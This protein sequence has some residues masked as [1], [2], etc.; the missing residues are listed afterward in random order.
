[1]IFLKRVLETLVIILVKLAVL[2][3]GGDAAEGFEEHLPLLRLVGDHLDVG[4]RLLRHLHQRLDEVLLLRQLVDVVAALGAPHLAEGLL[5]GL[6]LVEVDDPSLLASALPAPQLHQGAPDALG[7]QEDMDVDALQRLDD[8]PLAVGRQPGVVADVAEE[9]LHDLPLLV[10]ADALE[11]V[12]RLVHDLLDA[13]DARVGGVD[14]RQDLVLQLVVDVVPLEEVLLGG[15]GSAD[16]DALE[17]RGVEEDLGH[18]LADPVEVLVEV[19]IP[20]PLEPAAALASRPVLPGDA[21]G[22]LPHDVGA[23]PLQQGEG[24][25]LRVHD[26]DAVG[27]L[28]PEELVEGLEHEPVLAAVVVCGDGLG[29]DDDVGLHVSDA[30]LVS[31]DGAGEDDEA[32]LRYP[33]EELEPL[34]HLGQGVLD[35]LL[36]RLRLDVARRPPLA[37]EVAHH[38]ADLL[39]RRDVDADELRAAPLP[40]L[41]HLQHPLEPEPAQGRVLLRHAQPSRG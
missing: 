33:P 8:L 39:P 29:G 16:D 23:P 11:E 35:V 30:G 18:V 2:E 5:E 9:V 7:E 15:S 40:L 17:V 4:A 22:D 38:L 31:G 28:G 32:R 27:V 3:D 20:E 10:E 21:R 24:G 6:Q 14:D 34:H 12:L 19:H 26:Q 37:A 1:M 41:Q 36:R 13:P 25:I